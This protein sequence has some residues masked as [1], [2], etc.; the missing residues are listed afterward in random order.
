MYDEDGVN[1]NGPSQIET[2]EPAIGPDIK[3]VNKL[4][5]SGARPFSRLS[6]L[7]ES[8]NQRE[9]YNEISHFYDSFIFPN[10]VP[11]QTQL[12]AS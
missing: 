9:K 1:E 7:T 4:M 6:E 10:C 2:R 12:G 3:K 11:F 5:Q 8:R